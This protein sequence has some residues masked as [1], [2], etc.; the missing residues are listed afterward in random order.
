MCA[1]IG[2]AW[3]QRHFSGWVERSA[4]CVQLTVKRKRAFT[5]LA[6]VRLRSLGL[7]KVRLRRREGADVLAVM[8]PR[9]VENG[10]PVGAGCLW[11]VPCAV[12]KGRQRSSNSRLLAG[13]P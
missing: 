13:I 8:T 10:Q 6:C 4:P 2:A 7:P 5:Y 9:I 3:Q 11:E 12:R 1:S